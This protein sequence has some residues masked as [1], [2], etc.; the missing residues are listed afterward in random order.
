MSSLMQHQ[1]IVHTK[2]SGIAEKN[3]SSKTTGLDDWK[4]NGY[5]STFYTANQACP[6]SN[7]RLFHYHKAAKDTDLP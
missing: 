7:P 1:E 6:K 4:H 3:T 5:F 2:Y